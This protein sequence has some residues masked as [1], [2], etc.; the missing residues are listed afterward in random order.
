VV[1]DGTRAPDQRVRVYTNGTFDVAAAETAASIAPH[2]APLRI[3]CMPSPG[4]GTMQYF[5]GLLDE[6]AI[7]TRALTDPEIA[8]WYTSTMP[9]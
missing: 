9:R 4:S 3:G 5:V 6:V 1:F 8:Q 7:W 2:T